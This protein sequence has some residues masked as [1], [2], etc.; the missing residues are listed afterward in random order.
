MEEFRYTWWCRMLRNGICPVNIIKLDKEKVSQVFVDVA[1]DTIE[2]D[3]YKDCITIY[4]KIDRDP[5]TNNVLY[6]HYYI[7]YEGHMFKIG[8][9]GYIPMLHTKEHEVIHEFQIKEFEPNKRL[10]K[11]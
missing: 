5:D 8:S 7:F 10:I 6:F 9:G 2:L 4:H 11:E 3:G 1:N